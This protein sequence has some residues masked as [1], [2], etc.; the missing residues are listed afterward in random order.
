MKR[1]VIKRV[2]TDGVFGTFG[3]LIEGNIPFA[4]TL[5]L[6]WKNNERKV[7]C[8]PAT[9]EGTLYTCMRVNSPKFGNVFQIMNVPGRDHILLHPGNTYKDI[10]GCIIV[11]EQFE[12]LGGIPAVVSSKKGFSELMGRVESASVFELVIMWAQQAKVA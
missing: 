3:V 8:I 7:S 10:E 11:A 1:F 9:Q 6:P 5:E 4:L 2:S 12:Y